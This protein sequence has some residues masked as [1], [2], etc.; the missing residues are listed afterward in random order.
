MQ[1]LAGDKLLGNLPFE[2]GAMRTMLGH[3][4]HPSKAQHRRSIQNSHS[5]RPQGRTPYRRPKLTPLF[6]SVDGSARPGEAGRGCA[7]GASAGPVISK[8]E[9]ASCA[10]LEAPA[11]VAGLDD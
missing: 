2:S 3:G 9:E 4:F 10:M 1:G 5:V 8:G 11:F 7:A 6:G